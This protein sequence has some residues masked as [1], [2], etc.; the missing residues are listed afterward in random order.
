MQK[1][2]PQWLDRPAA[3]LSTLSALAGAALVFWSAVSGDYWW[4]VWAA[5]VFTGAGILWHVAD[6]SAAASPG[7]TR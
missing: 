7:G 4:A 6:F 2:I 1:R 3:V 5:V